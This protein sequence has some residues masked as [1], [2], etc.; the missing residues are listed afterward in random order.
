MFNVVGADGVA[1]G[2]ITD[3]GLRRNVE[4]PVKVIL[5]GKPPALEGVLEES[6]PN[7]GVVN[8][9]TFHILNPGDVLEIPRKVSPTNVTRGKDPGYRHVVY[10]GPSVAKYVSGLAYS[11]KA[12]A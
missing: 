9:D 8:R 7:F 3:K 4:K 11:K 12:V 1:R 6:G 10:V 5:R 2:S